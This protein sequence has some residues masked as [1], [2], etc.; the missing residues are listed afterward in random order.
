MLTSGDKMNTINIVKIYK[1][2]ERVAMSFRLTVF[3][4][5]FGKGKSLR[6]MSIDILLL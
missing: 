6:D 2:D 1:D 5:L 4:Y 3:H